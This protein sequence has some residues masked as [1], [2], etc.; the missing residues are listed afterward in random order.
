MTVALVDD[1][2]LVRAGF[3]MVIDSQDDMS[4]A[5]QASDGGEAI[6]QQSASPVD[7]ILMDVQMP[8][9]DGITATRSIVA[10]HPDTRVVVLTTFDN[11]QYLV[12][13]IAAGASGFLLKDAQPEELL[14]AI[15]TV[16]SGESVLAAAST[17]RLLRT[18]RPLLDGQN[19]VAAGTDSGPQSVQRTELADP[20]TE[21]ETEILELVARGRS[22]AE[23]ASDLFI[24]LPTVKTHVSHILAKTGSRDRVQA[25]V[26]AFRNG[27]V[28]PDELLEG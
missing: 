24:S 11:D 25:V 22:N 8:G 13:A 10:E 18:V 9:T 2:M 3:G 4:V 28:S 21:R 17:A 16:H 1:Q 23:I 6:A 5:W 12:D 14:S 7:L 15:R 20:L 27:Y 19:G 26:F